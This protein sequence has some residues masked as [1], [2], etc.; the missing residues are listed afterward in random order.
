MPDLIY[1]CCLPNHFTLENLRSRSIFCRHPHELNDLFEFWAIV[2]DGLPSFDDDDEWFQAAV[3]AWGF[4]GSKITDL[5]LGR[6]TYLQYFGDLADR[7][8]PMNIIYNPARV[9]CFSSDPVNL[10]MWSH[11]A[12]GLRGCCLEYDGQC[13]VTESETTFV[14]DVEY[15]ESP[16]AIDTL[17]YAVTEDLFYYA[18]DHGY[19]EY[20]GEAFRIRLNSMMRGALASKPREWEYERELRLLVH[21]RQDDKAPIRHKYPVNALKSIIVGERMD[22]EYRTALRRVVDQLGVSVATQMAARS[23]DTYSLTL[24]DVAL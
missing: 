17:V 6:E 8:P 20:E 19:Q 1:K 4:P 16:P 14:A 21:T 12:D 22:D 23:P 10:L 24:R 3:A 2:R 7:A 9:S 5:P 11:Y 15:V 18:V 13:L